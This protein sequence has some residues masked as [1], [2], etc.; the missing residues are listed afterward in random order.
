MADKRLRVK[1]VRRPR[2]CNRCPWAQSCDREG[3]DRV[4]CLVRYLILEITTTGGKN[5]GT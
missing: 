1:E 3:Q 4:Y 2:E 5:N